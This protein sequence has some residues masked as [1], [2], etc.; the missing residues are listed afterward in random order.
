MARV[1]GQY[2]LAKKHGFACLNSSK[3]LL[4]EK[5]VETLDAYRLLADIGYY[6]QAY[7]LEQNYGDTALWLCESAT[8][9]DSSR[10]TSLLVLQAAE[11]SKKAFI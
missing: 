2:E 4:G 3:K 10:Y 5:D 11:K 8:P 1:I 6:S 9:L 7:E